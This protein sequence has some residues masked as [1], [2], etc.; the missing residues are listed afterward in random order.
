MSLSIGLRA[1]TEAPPILLRKGG[2]GKADIKKVPQ[3]HG[4]VIL[5]DFGDKSWPTRLLGR[6]QV[7]REIRALERLRHLPGVPEYHGRVGPYGVLMERM[8]GERITRWCEKNP[9]SRAVM[10]DRLSRLVDLMHRLGV[11]HMDLRKRDNILVTRDGHPCI[12]DFNASFCFRPR[13]LGGRIVF[14]LFR[15]IDISAILKWKSRLAPELL[16][17][18]ER[19]INRWMSQLRRLWIFN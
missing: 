4:H 16:T 6:V 19:R 14:P 8:E 15:W 5:K 10:F 12:I 7:R 3:G 11:A 1:E 13:A 18:R 9:G 17:A 2:R